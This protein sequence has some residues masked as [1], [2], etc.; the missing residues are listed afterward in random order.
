MTEE[1]VKMWK[2]RR[3]E[4]KSIEDPKAREAALDIV[5][6]MKDDMQLDCQRKMADRIK[7][8]VASDDIQGKKIDTIQTD[9]GNLKTQIASHA[10]IINAVKEANSQAKGMW[11]LLKIIGILA[12]IGG[13][14]VAGWF[15]ALAKKAAETP[16]L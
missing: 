15:L 13:S 5:Y 8:L 11:N 12:S 16:S 6:D 7:G 4:A 9:V 3:D 14:G 1:Q 2:V 10:P